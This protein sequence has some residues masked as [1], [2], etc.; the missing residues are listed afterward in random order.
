MCLCV[1]LSGGSSQRQR[2][3]AVQ[4]IQLCGH[5]RRG[6]ATTTQYYCSGTHTHLHTS[7][8]SHNLQN[9]KVSEFMETK[10]R[11]DKETTTFKCR[12]FIS[13]SCVST[14]VTFPKSVK[15]FQEL[16]LFPRVGDVILSQSE[17][18]LNLST[19]TTADENLFKVTQAQIHRRVN[20]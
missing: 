12:R 16:G 20:V 5:N 17:V 6:H 8:K 10:L 15:T 1:R 14:K 2:P 11:K 3:S 4:R 9:Y 19:S 18:D 7:P 13:C